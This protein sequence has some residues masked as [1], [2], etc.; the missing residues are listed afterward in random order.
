MGTCSFT[1]RILTM[2]KYTL[3]LASILMLVSLLNMEISAEPVPEP[4]AGADP[5]DFVIVPLDRYRQDSVPM[6][7]SA[8]PKPVG[9]AVENVGISG[10]GR[11]AQPEFRSSCCNKVKVSYSSSA[12]CS[13]SSGPRYEQS[14]LYG[15]NPGYFMKQSWTIN[16]KTWYKSGNGEMAI[17]Y[18][19]DKDQWLVG[20]A[21]D[22]GSDQCN[23]YTNDGHKNCPEDVYWTWRYTKSGQWKNADRC[24]SIY[25]A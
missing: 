5:K 20:D 21:E 15:S 18:H 14:N 11:R 1:I 8:R 17:W 23:A 7:R 22:L 24:F 13:S 3:V 2:K 19:S 9:N 4:V 6:F 10:V 25:C 16:G 12:Y